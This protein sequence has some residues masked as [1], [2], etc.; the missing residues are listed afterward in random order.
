[1]KD[2]KKEIKILTIRNGFWII[3]AVLVAFFFMEF[4]KQ[5]P[6]KKNMILWLV[7]QIK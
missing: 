6:W 7:L 1:M 4:S 2:F 5:I 3:L